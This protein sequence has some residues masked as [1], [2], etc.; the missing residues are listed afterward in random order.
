MLQVMT[1]GRLR[2]AEPVAITLLLPARFVSPNWSA[3]PAS[4]H[5]LSMSVLACGNAF[6]GTMHHQTFRSPAIE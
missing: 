1:F 2:S 6:P 3:A 5:F 4:K